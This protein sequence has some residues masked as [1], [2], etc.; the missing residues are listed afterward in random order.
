VQGRFGDA[1]VRIP[2]PVVR[3]VRRLVLDSRFPVLRLRLPVPGLE[4]P[5]SSPESPFIDIRSVHS[6]NRSVREPDSRTSM[7]RRP[8]GAVLKS[9]R[10][11]RIAGRSSGVWSECR[12][13]ISV[14]ISWS[15]WPASGTRLSWSGWRAQS[16]TMFSVSSTASRSTCD[17]RLTSCRRLCAPVLLCLCRPGQGHRPESAPAAACLFLVFA[18]LLCHHLRLRAARNRLAILRPG[19]G[20]ALR[21]NVPRSRWLARH[22]PTRH[23]DACVPPRR[24]VLGPVRDV[25]A[26]ARD[27][28]IAIRACVPHQ[29][30]RPSWPCR[31]R[32]V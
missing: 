3:A 19:C 2:K 21:R 7:R 18:G 8:T 15:H 16:P 30:D 29:A 28:R 10:L 6:Y 5:V 27:R 13:G 25:R 22:R 11:N 17:L 14:R 20:G 31:L 1:T 9:D 24:A 23:A 26:R 32:P 12:S 4:S